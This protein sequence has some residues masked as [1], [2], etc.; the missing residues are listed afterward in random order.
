MLHGSSTMVRLQL[1]ER[2]WQ[3]VKAALSVREARRAAGA[4][5]SQLRGGG[6]VVEAYGRSMARSSERFWP[7]EDSVQSVRPLG[8]QGDL[9]P[10][11]R[12]ALSGPRQ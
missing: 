1:D 9:A 5:R 12:S 7:L 6:T 8:E 10:S 4:G 3:K 11:V 2:Q